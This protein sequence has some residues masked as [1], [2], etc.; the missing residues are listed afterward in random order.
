M[1]SL[2]AVLYTYVFPH[3]TVHMMGKKELI[4][5]CKSIRVLAS[6]PGEVSKGRHLKLRNKLGG[7]L[8]LYEIV[9]G[10][11]YVEGRVGKCVF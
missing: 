10:I 4:F 9:R 5:Q 3:C 7:P 8:G 2:A 1:L 6:M 11:E